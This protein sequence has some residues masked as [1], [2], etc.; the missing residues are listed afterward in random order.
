MNFKDIKNVHFIGIGGIGMSA[1]ARY[2]N[3]LDKM[4]SGYDRASTD[5][6]KKLEEEGI[7]VYH[8]ENIDLIPEEVFENPSSSK[9]LIVYTPAIPSNHAELEFFRKNNVDLI[10]R[11]E[12]LGA[13]SRN[14]STVGIAGTHG[15][16]TT[17]SILTF[18]CMTANMEFA[19][20][21]GG[22]NENFKS[23]LVIKGSPEFVI[24]EADEYDRSFLKLKPRYGIIT[25]M[26]ADHLDIYESADNM[27]EAFNEFANLIDK[28]GLLL[29]CKNVEKELTGKFKTYGLVS[30]ADYYPEN[31]KYE[32][33]YFHFNFIG[34]GIEF[35]DMKFALPGYHNLENA[36]AAIALSIELGANENA[37]SKALLDYK[38]VKRRFE[39]LIDTP[40][41]I[42]IDD[43]AHHPEE[44]NAV[45]SSLRKMYPGKKITGIFQP[46][47]FSRTKDFA[48]EFARSL[49][50][51]DELIL[52]EIYPA[53]EEPIPGITSEWLLEK[54]NLQNK[55]SCHKNELIKKLENITPEILITL[56]AGDIDQIVIPV[57]NHYSK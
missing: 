9:N 7:T 36:I 11:S 5:L 17:T 20:F 26:D 28:D 39:F 8:E 49:E 4:V 56:G 16:T 29:V 33:G 31:T 50:K 12:I 35:K 53:R 42:Y 37:I 34:P 27:T 54:V 21:V 40:E 15:K 46:H 47:L 25:S 55:S 38:G 44:I 41:L 48:D 22:I 1:L 2:F 6:T 30:T 14:Y 13:I 24:I 45:L 19:S 32:N 51:L 57:K 52:L 18:I 10:K 43:Y 3:H 23:N